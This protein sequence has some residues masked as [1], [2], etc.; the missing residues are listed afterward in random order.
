MRILAISTT[1]INSYVA[2]KN[3]DLIDI[4]NVV[5]KQSEKLLS[6]IDEVLTENNI[7]LKDI[8]CFAVNVGPGSFTGIRIGLATIKAFLFSQNKPCVVLNSFDLVSYNILDKDFIVIVDSGNKDFYYAIYKNGKIVELS[9]L[10]E[11]L[12]IMQKI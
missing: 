12:S 1:N 2:L 4:K 6:T 9:N 7:S 11:Q 5:D 3:N 10:D 8:D